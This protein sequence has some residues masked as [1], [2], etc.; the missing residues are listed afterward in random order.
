HFRGTSVADC[1]REFDTLVAGVRMR[2][3][4]MAIHTIAA[5]GGSIVEFDGLKFKVGPASA[6]A[7]P[8]PACYR[9]GGP[10]T[11]TDCNVLLG[12]VQPDFFPAAFGASS[13]QIIDRDV[14]VEKF[15]ALAAEVRG[16]TGREITKEEVAEGF[17]RIAVSNMANA[18]KVISVQRGYDVT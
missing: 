6:G 10:L 2:A 18:I 4:M 15:D 8:G 7:N 13:D 11:A 17:L 16:A 14:V 1:E 9:R 12:K 5:G 3:P